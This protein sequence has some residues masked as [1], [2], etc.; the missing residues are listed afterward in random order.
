MTVIDDLTPAEKK[1]I[2]ALKRAATMGRKAGL[3]IF[4][5]AGSLKVLKGAYIVADLDIPND[6][7]DPQEGEDE[8]GTYIEHLKNG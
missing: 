4:A 8:D 5:W 7:G 2:A 6:G 3:S 1:A